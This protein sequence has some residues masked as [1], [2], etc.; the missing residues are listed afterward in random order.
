VRGV[1]RLQYPDVRFAR[2]GIFGK[3]LGPLL[4]EVGHDRPLG[5]SEHLARFALAPDLQQRAD[6][7][8]CLAISD[9]ETLSPFRRAVSF[10][11]SSSRLRKASLMRRERV[12]VCCKVSAMYDSL[13]HV[14]HTCNRRISKLDWRLKVKFLL[15]EPANAR[16]P[17]FRWFSY[18]TK[19][20]IQLPFWGGVSPLQPMRSIVFFFEPCI[21]PGNSA[22]LHAMAVSKPSENATGNRL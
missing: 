2:E 7:S 13:I 14:C 1:E 12:W 4:H 5:A 21:P 22:I 6:S 15:W 10:R 20:P 8:S 16:G 11:M 17:V 19:V 18:G 9:V 3:R